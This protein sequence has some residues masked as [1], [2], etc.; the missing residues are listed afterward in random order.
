M[1]TLFKGKKNGYVTHNANLLHIIEYY[2]KNNE[3]NNCKHVTENKIHTDQASTQ[4]KCI[5]TFIK[6]ATFGREHNNSRLIHNFSEK[7]FF[8]GA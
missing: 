2:D 1:D 7:Y 8:K 5:K 6:I 4:F 3:E